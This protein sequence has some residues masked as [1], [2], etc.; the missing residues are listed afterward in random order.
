M[1]RKISLIIAMLFVILFQTK[2]QSIGD[3]RTINSGDWSSSS[4]W[5]RYDGA[6]WQP[7]P[8]PPSLGD[9]A[10]NIRVGNTVNII[11]PI[12]ID[13]VFIN[14]GA[15]LNINT[16]ITV[17]VPVNTSP[18][19]AGIR[20]NG[21]TLNVNGK[22]LCQGQ[23]S[24][25]GGTINFNNG[26][27]YEHAQNAGAIP[28]ST[29]NTGS[30]CNITGVTANAPSNANQNYSDFTWNCP[31]QTA[32]VN[33]GWHAN[34]VTGTLRVLNCGA[35]AT[36]ALRLSN[37][38]ANGANPITLTVNNIEVQK[39]LLTT[40]GSS[41]AQIYTFNV[42][43][44][45]LVT[46]TG[47]F[48]IS[49]GSGG[50]VNVNLFGNLTINST[51]ANSYARGSGT[52]NTI[53]SKNG[54]QV[55]TKDPASTISTNNTFEVLSNAIVDLNNSNI[56]NGT[57]TFTVFS[58]GGITTSAAG[59]FNEN[60]LSSTTTL[61][62]SATGNYGFYGTAVQS[63]GSKFAAAVSAC[64]N[65]IINNTGAALA[66]TVKLSGP[67]IV[68]GTLTLTDGIV[69]PSTT[70]TLTISETGSI[71]G[72]SSNSYIAR[73]LTRVTNNTIDYLFP[74]GKDGNYRPF[75]I[76]PNN[77]TLTSYYGEYYRT[78][79]SNTSSLTFPITTVSTQEYWE[80]D[81]ITGGNGSAVV[82]IDLFASQPGGDATN[83]VGLGHFKSGSWNWE[84]G[85]ALSPGNSSS[86][87]LQTDVVNTFSPFT[88]VILDAIALPVNLL[89]ITAQY[90]GSTTTIKWSTA[91]ESNI[92][93]YVVERS[94]DGRTFSTLGFLHA[95]NNNSS[96]QYLFKHSA[97]ES[98]IIYFRIKIIENDGSIRLS[99]IVTINTKTTLT[100]SIYPNPVTDII[101]VVVPKS[102]AAS[103]INIFDAQG[104]RVLQ[105]KV[106]PGVIS[107][108]II[109]A[110]LK[111]GQYTLTVSSENK[112]QSVIFVK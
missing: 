34:T 30:I 25:A 49:S 74:V 103:V 20:A 84:G 78:A 47:V 7:M 72:G 9:A 61:N 90:D 70:N 110:Y 53:F 97:V 32:S 8:V 41:G 31:S 33:L 98:G 96:N 29:W 104:K 112:K 22:I 108:N 39:N 58:G 105:E 11:T 85:T 73:R 71:A 64:N 76:T 91:N 54:T 57:T 68:N 95:N 2:A 52:T 94:V 6:T 23:V 35:T 109:V 100:V 37:S 4:I 48:N 38:A 102:N 18:A 87:T 17:T 12:S 45:I 80:I 19:I 111:Q 16:G 10:I 67:I 42:L 5:E 79:Y 43:G 107:T 13:S 83:K 92:Q 69:L 27:E 89:N 86:G 50:T 46:G 26:S 3:Y 24:N 93:R 51:V 77:T 99:K 62:L 21:G 66:D 44:N 60:F 15:V 56:S 63:T 65:L 106:A 40:N 1:K 101:N 28:V 14:A 82:K 81:T 75:T 88:Y 55:Y 59:G 36:T